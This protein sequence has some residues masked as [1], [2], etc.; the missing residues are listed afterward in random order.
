ML[1]L[2]ETDSHFSD[3]EPTVNLI[4]IDGSTAHLIKQASDQRINEFVADLAPK[5]GKFYLHILAMGAGEYFGA[6]RN[7]D[8]FPEENLIRY[9]KTFEDTGHVFR[10]HVN[11]DPARSIGKVIYAIYNERMHRVELVAEVD[12]VLGKDLSDR[13]AKGEYPATSM[14]CKTP[15]DECSVCGNKA[16]SRQAYCDHLKY[17]LGKIL[18]DGNKVMS[19]NVAPLRF[20]D[21][22]IVIKPAD[23]TSSVLQKVA[24]VHDVIGSAELAEINGLVEKSAKLMKFSELIKEIRGTVLSSTPALDKLIANSDPDW[25]LLEPLSHLPLNQ[26]ISSFV[27][28]GMTPSSRFL[29]ELIALKHFGSDGVGVGELADL[30]TKSTGATDF[31]IPEEFPIEYEEPSPHILKMLTPQIEKASMFQQAIE[32]RASLGYNRFGGYPQDRIN[33]MPGMEYEHQQQ[34]EWLPGV[35]KEQEHGIFKTLLGIGVSALLTKWFISREIEKQLGNRPQVRPQIIMVKRA[36]QLEVQGMPEQP[37]PQNH[38]ML[39]SI[40]GKGLGSMHNRVGR[41]GAS[42]VRLLKYQSKIEK[43]QSQ[44]ATIL[45]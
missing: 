45:C 33:A 41:F 9:Y 44:P 30:V 2:L 34:A 6:N 8:Y 1:K 5:P 14:A 40:A 37:K 24:H 36:M 31:E 20:F 3:L 15:Y 42:I 39:L 23:V 26:V 19:L 25:A 27:K 43:L 10:N 17:E 28:L 35:T 21:I 11:K 32:K 18:P 38:G 16:T 29:A 7:Q 4:Q 13:I 22:S 12:S